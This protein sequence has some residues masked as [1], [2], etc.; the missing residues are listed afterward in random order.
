MKISEKQ[1]WLLIILVV[2]YASATT[3]GLVKSWSETATGPTGDETYLVDS[4]EARDAVL[5]SLSSALPP[6]QSEVTLAFHYGSLTQ[7]MVPGRKVFMNWEKV[8]KGLIIIPTSSLTAKTKPNGDPD[9][10][11]QE[12]Y[13]FGPSFPTDDP[14]N[15]ADRFKKTMES[16]L[17]KIDKYKNVIVLLLDIS[18]RTGAPERTIW[19]VTAKGVAYCDFA[20]RLP[21][22]P[23]PW[24][25]GPQMPEPN[26]IKRPF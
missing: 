16:E 12:I 17:A 25:S 11:V 23:F 6:S 5:K 18:S 14:Y 26:W 13:G 22:K 21:V 8:P 20:F 4:G 10:Y 1:A 7:Y 15:T 9:S 3:F 24:Q 2:L 19:S